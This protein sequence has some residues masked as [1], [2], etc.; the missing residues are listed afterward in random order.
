M[1]IIDDVQVGSSLPQQPEESSAP[2]PPHLLNGEK[3]VGKTVSNHVAKAHPSKV[4]TPPVDKAQRVQDTPATA[5]RFHHPQMQEVDVPSKLSTKSRDMSAQDQAHSASDDKPSSHDE[6]HD[7]HLPQSTGDT[8]Y[9]SAQDDEND[10]VTQDAGLEGDTEVPSSPPQLIHDSHFVTEKSKVSIANIH[11]ISKKS[12]I[13]GS[14]QHEGQASNM[15]LDEAA[16]L[17]PL[18]SELPSTAEN[19][20]LPSTESM[21]AALL[22][23][24]PE[25]RMSTLKHNE[26]PFATN[27]LHS[28][29]TESDTGRGRT[30]KLD[31]DPPLPS[32][33]KELSLDETDETQGPCKNH[34]ARD[35]GEHQSSPWSSDSS[36]Q[37]H[38][39]K[40]DDAGIDDNDQ[41]QYHSQ[42]NSPKRKKMELFEDKISLKETLPK[43]SLDYG[44]PLVEPMDE[45]LATQAEVPQATPASRKRG[46]P[47]KSAQTP[48]IATS[49]QATPLSSASR[50][51]GRPKEHADKDKGLEGQVEPQSIEQNGVDTSSPES[52]TAKRGRK[53]KI[54]ATTSIPTSAFEPA[55]GKKVKHGKGKALGKK[56]R[57]TMSC[58]EVLDRIDTREFFDEH[59]TLVESP[60][61]NDFDI[62]VVGAGKMQRTFKLLLAVALGK[63]VVSEK[64]ILD[65]QL[66]GSIQ[67][68]GQYLKR[69]TEREKEWGFDPLDNRDRKSLFEGKKFV[70]TPAVK[71]SCGDRYVEFDKL[72]VAVGGRMISKSAR[73]CEDDANN[74]VLG[75]DKGDADCISLMA[76]GRACYHRDLLTISTLRGEVDLKSDEFR[77]RSTGNGGTKGR[78]GSIGKRPASTAASESSKGRK[79][80]PRKRTT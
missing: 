6:A 70:V 33:P 2:R 17:P 11:A 16:Y 22:F 14:H 46:R 71:K 36:G 60:K 48:S 72:A 15:E 12:A 8:M 30:H 77:L 10:R 62:L 59:A 49:A 23:P 79:G 56:P 4:S 40:Y 28:D 13:E 26:E 37:P 76:K 64:W 80:R 51:R 61:T 31:E 3:A 55:H 24:Q 18:F 20:G 45:K 34:Q 53:R 75:L 73:E 41:Y 68:P 19:R 65:S 78:M 7:Q 43:T 32:A 54:D 39:R 38:K 35:N 5:Q 66:Q 63:P 50:G 52:P 47:R 57:V 9:K 44:K 58:S 25:S 27:I 67:N 1:R 21:H 29:Q 69:D 42:S 74:I